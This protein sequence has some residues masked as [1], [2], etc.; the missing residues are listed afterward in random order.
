MIE[1]IN[2]K[3]VETK[4]VDE[5]TAI[6]IASQDR[7][8]KD[9]IFL[10]WKQEDNIVLG[11]IEF[12]K[13][14]VG[15]VQYDLKYYWHIIVT[16][17]IFGGIE[18]ETIHIDGDLSE[19]DNISCFVDVKTGEYFDYEDFDEIMNELKKPNMKAFKKYFNNEIISWKD[20]DGN[21]SKNQKDLEDFELPDFLKSRR[22]I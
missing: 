21:N 15:L 6:A 19:D 11:L 22:D 13:F 10:K 1:N 14:K 18:N 4:C 16:D 20:V 8:L 3:E 9:Y 5:Q 2:Y 12:K 17:G 7:N